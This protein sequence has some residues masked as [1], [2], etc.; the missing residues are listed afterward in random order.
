M[1]FQ[2][3]S[4]LL[5]H[6]LFKTQR[7]RTVVSYI[8]LWL[9]RALITLGMINGGLGLLVNRRSTRA[10]NIAYGTIAAVIWLA[11]LVTSAIYEA[12]RLEPKAALLREERFQ[13]RE[14][15]RERR[16]QES[17]DKTVTDLEK[18]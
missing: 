7:Q 10:Q 1:F 14:K 11:Y 9:G 17:V 12:R 2:A 3:I 18:V 8:H 6:V 15:R 16:R 4:G 13:A 5:H